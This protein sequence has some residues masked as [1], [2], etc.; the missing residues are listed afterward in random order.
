MEEAIWLGK[1][2]LMFLFSAK[3]ITGFSAPQM[4]CEN[5]FKTKYGANKFLQ[6]VE[7]INWR[8]LNICEPKETGAY[9]CFFIPSSSTS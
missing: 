7:I 3:T 6:Y 1:K 9:A 5:R 4:K 2:L 8:V